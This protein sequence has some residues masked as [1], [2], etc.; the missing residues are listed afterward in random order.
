MIAP[1]DLGP[2]MRQQADSSREKRVVEPFAARQIAQTEKTVW[3]MFWNRI[4]DQIKKRKIITGAEGMSHES[5]TP[6]EFVERSKHRV[7]CCSL[8]GAVPQTACGIRNDR[9]REWLDLP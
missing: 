5:K 8:G 1:T 4:N 6:L 3:V 7:A 9:N 2:Q